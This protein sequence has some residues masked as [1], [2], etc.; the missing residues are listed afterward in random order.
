MLSSSVI[1]VAVFPERLRRIKRRW[2]DSRAALFSR[3]ARGEPL[4]VPLDARARPASCAPSLNGGAWSAARRKCVVSLP[5]PRARRRASGSASPCGAPQSSS[6]SLRKLDCY[7]AAILGEGTVL[8]GADGGETRP[9]IRTAFA[10][11]IRT[12]SSR[13]RQSHVVGPDGDP[14][15]PSIVF[16]RHTRRR[17]IL[18]RLKTPLESAPHEQDTA[19]ISAVQSTGMRIPITKCFGLSRHSGARVFARTRNLYLRL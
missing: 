17:R 4:V 1:A 8:P 13:E 11:F 3:T 16:A 18:L 7:L 5:A 6:R 19:N 9:L 2:H 10:A 12:A 15:L 14:S